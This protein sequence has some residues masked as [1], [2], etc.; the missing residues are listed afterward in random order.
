MELD[1]TFNDGKVHFVCD[2]D[3]DYPD[4]PII[5][6]GL[7]DSCSCSLDTNNVTCKKCIKWITRIMEEPK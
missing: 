1:K 4:C 7:E 5:A 6:C 3:A 2:F